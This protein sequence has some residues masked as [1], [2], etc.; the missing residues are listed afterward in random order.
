[1]HTPGRWV[2]VVFSKPF[3]QGAAAAAAAR[4]M[5]S[6]PA[7]RYNKSS[8]G[9]FVLT[10]SGVNKQHSETSCVS[11]LPAL[12]P[13]ASKRRLNIRLMLGF[14]CLHLTL[15]MNTRRRTPGSGSSVQPVPQSTLCN[16]YSYPADP[17]V[18]GSLLLDLIHSSLREYLGGDR[19]CLRECSFH[20]DRISKQESK[21]QHQ[22]SLYG[23]ASCRQDI[24]AR[25]QTHTNILCTEPDTD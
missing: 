13:G 8:R 14:E 7:T 2:C 18:M 15:C 16:E 1:M 21:D 11:L 20:V 17:W 24:K 4:V 22:H 12:G 25:K 19:V 9:L 5:C 3:P 23:P 6:Q 10:V